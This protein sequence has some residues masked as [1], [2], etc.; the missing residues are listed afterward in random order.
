M[1]LING[2]MQ[3]TAEMLYNISNDIDFQLRKQYRK[4]IIEKSNVMNVEGHRIMLSK[5]NEEQD[6]EIL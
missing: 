1:F 3:H 2:T 6:K 5:I 4:E